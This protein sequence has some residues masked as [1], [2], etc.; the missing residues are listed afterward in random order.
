MRSGHRRLRPVRIPLP[1]MEEFRID[2]Y[3]YVLMY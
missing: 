1:S 2:G 3:T